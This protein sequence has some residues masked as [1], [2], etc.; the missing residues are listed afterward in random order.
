MSSPTGTPTFVDR[1]PEEASV[2]RQAFL[3]S[4]VA[5]GLG[6]LFGIIQALHRTNVLR[7]IDSADY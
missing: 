7:L 6:A 2:V 5:L 1:Y 4:F 3:V